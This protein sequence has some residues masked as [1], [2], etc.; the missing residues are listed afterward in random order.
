M[1]IQPGHGVTSKFTCQR[2]FFFFQWCKMVACKSRQ[3]KLIC[4]HSSNE[5]SF[6]TAFVRTLTMVRVIWIPLRRAKWPPFVRA[7][8]TGSK[9]SL[10]SQS[11]QS[12]YDIIFLQDFSKS[13]H[14]TQR[15]WNWAGVSWRK[16]WRG[17]LGFHNSFP[18]V[19]E[20]FNSFIL[21]VLMYLKK[22]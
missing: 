22:C 19:W 21:C 15:A 13:S 17:V 14:F 2:W 11:G 12:N 3:K 7:E 6:A 20:F 16:H 5:V 1:Y 4:G 10:S 18:L 8:H 9:A